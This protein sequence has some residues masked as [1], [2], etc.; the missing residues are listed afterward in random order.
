[1]VGGDN[2]SLL[3]LGVQCRFIKT[4]P[5][6]TVHVVYD[7]RSVLTDGM[8]TTL[9]TLLSI[10]IFCGQSQIILLNIKSL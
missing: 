8:K 5:M 2:D 7:Q 9:N 10:S 3:M 6:T 4:M 1:M